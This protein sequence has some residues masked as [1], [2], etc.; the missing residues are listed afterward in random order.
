MFLLNGLRQQRNP[1]GPS[2]TTDTPDTN[3]T[4]N[5]AISGAETASA[6][7]SI[8]SC[9]AR[10]HDPGN[11][12]G[13]P[14]FSS[15]ATTNGVKAARVSLPGPQSPEK[16]NL[17]K[18]LQALAGRI[19]FLEARTSLNGGSF[20]STPNEPGSGSPFPSSAAVEGHQPNQHT[21]EG[22]IRSTKSQPA[23]NASM[24][25]DHR[26]LWVNDWLAARGDGDAG[27][28]PAIPLTEEQLGYLRD[29]VNRQAEQIQSQRD[30]IEELSHFVRRQ[31][32]EQDQALGEGEQNYEQLKRELVKNQ[33]ANLAFQKAL[34]EIGSIITAVANGDLSKKVLIHAKE[35]DP[36]ITKF[37][38]TINKMVDQL[39]EF[40]QQVTL[41][42]REV[43]TEGKLGGQAVVPDVS[44][45]WAEL[46]ENGM[47]TATA[48]RLS[49]SLRG[50]NA[51]DEQ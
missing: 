32:D 16:E 26:T 8:V 44:G 48:S 20:P 41:L 1:S 24:S 46:T 36:E 10:Q 50:T 43:G 9:L 17:E 23:R 47:L 5:M 31:Q 38:R 42:A 22:A 3:Y 37:K 19:Q 11:E 2:S 14:S 49:L 25:K 18:E 4:A 6:V 34:R 39:Q 21:T 28:Q 7:T 40:A 45:I 29:H 27:A 51:D 12:T 35:L 33:Q 15:T 13:G 30:H